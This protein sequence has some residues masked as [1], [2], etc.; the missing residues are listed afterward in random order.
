MEATQA[1]SGKHQTEGPHVGLD[2]VGSEVPAENEEEDEV[3]IGTADGPQGYMRLKKS[4]SM[5]TNMSKRSGRESPNENSDRRRIRSLFHRPSKLL[6]NEKQDVRH[7]TPTSESNSWSLDIPTSTQRY[8]GNL[9]TE[10]VGIYDPITK[11]W[12]TPQK[13]PTRTRFGVYDP[14][15]KQWMAP[16][17]RSDSLRRVIQLNK[18]VSS[19]T[20]RDSGDTEATEDEQGALSLAEKLEIIRYNPLTRTLST[21]NTSVMPNRP[22][23]ADT[24]GQSTLASHHENGKAKPWKPGQVLGLSGPPE[25]DLMDPAH[26]EDDLTI[27]FPAKFTARFTEVNRSM[28]SGSGYMSFES[29]YEVK[30][31]DWRGLFKFKNVHVGSKSMLRRVSNLRKPD[32]GA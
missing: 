4:F 11:M 22:S 10:P 14:D 20:N 8:T 7:D 5:L 12:L 28:E 23:T 18:S 26:L 21:P 25:E 2:V 31:R 1:A 15:S 13:S 24:V 19:T 17:P 16:S 9:G 6:R 32:G 29:D 27:A 30:G 3:L